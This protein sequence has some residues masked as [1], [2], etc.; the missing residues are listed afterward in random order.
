M[1]TSHY[2]LLA[3][4]LL[5]SGLL[6]ACSMQTSPVAGEWMAAVDFG[7]IGFIVGSD[8]ASIPQSRYELNQFDCAGS[9]LSAAI[10]HEIPAVAAIVNGSFHD[11]TTLDVEGTQVIDVTIN[12]SENGQW[13]DGYYEI[14]LQHGSCSGEFEAFPNG[15]GT[16]Y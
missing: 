11:H 8:G 12:F 7:R 16:T 13:A 6:A 1:K 10:Q 14:S 4:L 15:L 9:T 3:S 2:G 5:I